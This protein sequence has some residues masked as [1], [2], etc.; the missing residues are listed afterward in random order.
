MEMPGMILI[1]LKFRALPP[2]G[3]KG[4]WKPDREA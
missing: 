3:Q 1:H 2:P 4:E